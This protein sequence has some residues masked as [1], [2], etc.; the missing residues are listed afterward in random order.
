MFFRKMEEVFVT[1]FPNSFG[2]FAHK[3]KT[4]LC[5]YTK[6]KKT[7]KLCPSPFASGNFL[8]YNIGVFRRTDVRRPPIPLFGGSPMIGCLMSTMN[9]STLLALPTADIPWGILIAELIAA[10]LLLVFTF[11]VRKRFLKI[12]CICGSE[13]CLFL[14]CKLTFGSEALVTNIMRWITAA[15]ACIITVSIVNRIN[16]SDL[17]DKSGNNR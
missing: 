14:A 4:K 8:C 6:F 15:V 11:L 13:V 2:R 1:N 17:R 16:W 3:P 12:I 9:L 7:P 5:I 10:V